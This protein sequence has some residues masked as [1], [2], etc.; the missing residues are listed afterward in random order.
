MEIGDTIET[1]ETETDESSERPSKASRSRRKNGKTE[2]GSGGGKTRIGKRD[3]NGGGGARSTE[4]EVALLAP[5]GKIRDIDLRRLLAA[6]S[7]CTTPI[8]T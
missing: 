4:Q 3:G 5:D 2:G 7:S 1:E 6:G 8:S